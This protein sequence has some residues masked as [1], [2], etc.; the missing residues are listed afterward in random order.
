VKRALPFDG[1]VVVPSADGAIDFTV[2]QTGL[3]GRSTRIVLL[4]CFT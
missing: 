3:K 2:L 4:I 1:E